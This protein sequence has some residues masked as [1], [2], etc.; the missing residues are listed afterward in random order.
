MKQTACSLE[1]KAHR[2]EDELQR[3]SRGE[4][5]KQKLPLEIMLNSNMLSSTLRTEEYCFSK[6]KRHFEDTAQ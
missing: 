4:I 5:T 6:C 1:V 3:D 2:H